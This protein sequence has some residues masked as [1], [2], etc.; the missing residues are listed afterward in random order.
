MT[1]TDFNTAF[2]SFINYFLQYKDNYSLLT[3]TAFGAF[4][5]TFPSTYTKLMESNN[6]TH[7]DKT[8]FFDSVLNLIIKFNAETIETSSSSFLKSFEN[9]PTFI[10]DITNAEKMKLVCIDKHADENHGVFKFD[11]QCSLN[12]FR[13]NFLH[14]INMQDENNELF[15]LREKIN[16]LETNQS[17]SSNIQTSQRERNLPENFD[18]AFWLFDIQYGK[19]LTN[20]NHINIFN[21]HLTQ[22]TC[23][24]PLV[25]SNFPTPFLPFDSDYINEYNDLILEFQ[26][27]ALKLGIK[28]CEK[29]VT[30]NNDTINTYKTKYT[31]TDNLNE[32]LND[33]KIKKERK[34]KSKFDSENER[35]LRYRRQLIRV[36]SKDSRNDSS[37][38]QTHY[39][40]NTH[41]TPSNKSN[42]FNHQGSKRQRRDRSRSTHENHNRSRS[43]NQKRYNNK[44][45]NNYSNNNNRRNNNQSQS[46]QEASSFNENS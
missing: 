23:T 12:T 42:S 6:N 21:T 22:K 36:L 31:N 2:K 37:I 4:K 45:P 38:N 43:N 30:V 41:S 26:Q 16:R 44:R 33:I 11:D 24:P 15:L 1:T 32:K 28:Y 10:N 7:I 8:N 34:L 13:E 5:R 35:V 18:D 25:C 9:F 20:Q 3:P 29:R 19:L 14:K 39:R 46:F 27:K 40:R 17:N